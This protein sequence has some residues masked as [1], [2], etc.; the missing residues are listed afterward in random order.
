MRHHHHQHTFTGGARKALALWLALLAPLFAHA[1]D[2][3]YTVADEAGKLSASSSAVSAT[4]VEASTTTV[5]WGSANTDTYYYVP[6]SVTMSKRVTV[7][8]HV[9]LILGD[10]ATLTCSAGITVQGTNS[11]TI[12]TGGPDA[13]FE[14]TGALSATGTQYQAGIGGNSGYAAG[15]ITINAGTVTAVGYASGQSYAAGIGGGRSG[16][17]GTVIINGGTV[18]AYGSQAKTSH[19][20]GIGAGGGSSSYAVGAGGTVIINGGTVSAYS[21]KSG[22]GYGAGIGGSS[23]GSGG[24]KNGST[25]GIITIKGGTV[26]AYSS[27][28]GSAFGAGIGGGAG[29]SA[30]YPGGSAGEIT[31]DGGTVNA[32]ASYSHIGNGAGIGTGNFGVG[33]NVTINGGTIKAY[34]ST[35][36]TGSINVFG[37]GIGA[38]YKGSGVAVVINDGDIEAYCTAATTGSAY[39]HGAGIGAGKLSAGA[40]VT[41]NGGTVKAACTSAH[42]GYG[43][44]IGSGYTSTKGC[45]I[46]ITGGTVEAYCCAFSG[47]NSSYCGYGAGIGSGYQSSAGT[48][49]ISGGTVTAVCTMNKYNQ[50]AYGAGIGCGASSSAT[51]YNGGTVEISGGTVTAYCG[52]GTTV[53]GTGIGGGRYSNGADV[54]ISGGTVTVSNG[55]G[56]GTNR[57]TA[58]SGKTLKVTGDE[59]VVEINGGLKYLETATAA[60]TNT[61]GN[62]V[63]CATYGTSSSSTTTKSGETLNLLSAPDISGQKYAKVWFTNDVY[64][65]TLENNGGSGATSTKT[66]KGDAFTKPDT[67]QREGYVFAGWYSDEA[68][69]TKY[70]FSTI[71]DGDIT[72]YA[73]W[74]VKPTMYYLDE[75]GEMLSTDDYTMIT[76]EDASTH[77]AWTSGIYAIIDTTTVSSRVTVTGEVTLI[78]GD[79]CQLNCTKGIT[80]EDGN[81]FV[82]TAGNTKEG[83]SESGVLT[84]TSYTGTSWSGGMYTLGSANAAIGGIATSN[85]DYTAT[86]GTIKIYGGKV[87]AYCT[88]NYSSA[89]GAGIGGCY[90]GKSGDITI[91]GGTISAAVYRGG[92]SYNN[93]GAIGS[94]SQAAAA[95]TLTIKGD[96]AKIMLRGTSTGYALKMAT[97]TVAATGDDY[98]ACVRYGNT[99]T[100]TT[101]CAKEYN[102]LEYPNLTSFQI[103]QVWFSNDISTVTYYN[104]GEVYAT[105]TVPTGYTIEKPAVPAEQDGKTFLGWYGSDDEKFDFSEEV[106]GSTDLYA[107]W[108]DNSSIGTVYYWD[109]EGTAQTVE[110]FS[111]LTGEMERD[112]LKSGFYVVYLD[113]TQYSTTRPQVVGDVTLVLMDDK[114]FECRPGIGVSTGNSLTIT[115]GHTSSDI[116]GTGELT[117]YTL[118]YSERNFPI[119]YKNVAIGGT[120]A[121]VY[122]ET[123]DVWTSLYGCGT[124]TINGG[125]VNAYAGYNEDTYNYGMAYGAGIGTAGVENTGDDSSL[126]GGDITIRRGTVTAYSFCG[127]GQGLGAGIGEG[128]INKVVETAESQVAPSDVKLNAEEGEDEGDGDG[129]DDGDEATTTVV[130]RKMNINILGGTVNAYSY[131]SGGVSESEYYYYF[132][133]GAGIGYGAYYESSDGGGGSVA[134]NRAGV[135]MLQSA[136][137]NEEVTGS[138]DATTS[139]EAAMTINIS[140]GTVKAYSADRGYSYG[141]GI[142][143][144]SSYFTNYYKNTTKSNVAP[145]DFTA[146]LAARAPR[147]AMTSTRV[148]GITTQAEEGD[149]EGTDDTETV[150]YDYTPTLSINISG[151]N[152]E[153]YSEHDYMG[154]GGGA[155]IG[156]A[157]VNVEKLYA[158]GSGTIVISDSAVVKAYS[159]TKYEW[160]SDYYGSVVYGVSAGIGIGDIYLSTSDSPAGSLTVKGNKA[161]VEAYGRESVN[162]TTSTA[163]AYDTDSLKYS[164]FIDYGTD[165]DNNERYHSKPVAEKENSTE[166]LLAFDT[167]NE[168]KSMASYTY[169]K[170]FF[171]P[172]IDHNIGSTGY[173]TMY[174]SKYNLIVPET[175]WGAMTYSIEN[176]MA[177]D[178]TADTLAASRIYHAGD[179]IPMGL[180]VVLRRASASS[181]TDH[182]FYVSDKCSE[183]ADTIANNLY[184]FDEAGNQTTGPNGETE[185]YVFY[186]LGVKNNNVGFYYGDTNGAPFMMKR[187]HTAYLAITKAAAANIACFLLGGEDEMDDVVTGISNAEADGKA[188]DHDVIYTLGGVRVKDTQNLPKGIYIK[189]GKK[190]LVQ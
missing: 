50:R 43:A 69:S 186:K 172:Y 56:A 85:S 100:D 59:A 107:H 7:A 190:I 65:A 92:F 3:Y 36:P 140:G 39:A 1:T 187:G 47:S 13:S 161:V 109:A 171:A 156:G 72:L 125:V 123:A 96:R 108:L 153:A 35:V 6:S 41:I 124:I 110:Q 42:T 94:G 40:T 58:G 176:T 10:G 120:A 24:N 143:Y 48:V 179:T 81:T 183:K 76:A 5:T 151:G 63:A 99:A 165:A 55:I 80:V 57:T 180:A 168:E 150:T 45:D 188:A 106:T 25:G 19:A 112:T 64:V 17:G 132:G 12:T 51:A 2:V 173:A 148:A 37:V 118:P 135:N 117:A 27:Y 154:Y 113:D 70:D 68:L 26:N 127:S 177:Y 152:V 53:Y 79:G 147:S 75:N 33:G 146:A 97:A 116:E 18:E 121:Y 141:A 157:C 34:C 149:E 91:T 54:T 145:G 4:D 22:A 105:R 122:D 32:Q 126:A 15:T 134:A 170:V 166:N 73:S 46:T 61:A 138:N 114:K 144:G 88:T 102:L 78:L 162:A 181:D 95:G 14:S 8:G 30:T 29:T 104:D 77:T 9:T 130:Y 60:A 83:I 131:G 93:A 119:E 139:T 164:V 182:F 133:Y 136:S 175:V 115:A 23:A 98:M 49:K 174:Y 11:F 67:P 89:N 84:A 66:L 86:A 137:A 128:Y 185:G 111:V 129:D 184:G 159:S 31:I 160:E 167:D 163:M 28:S 90:K 62:Y 20:A 189:N 169:G 87:N 74:M 71:A 21:S 158:L 178:T 82:I 103:A 142:G 52:P 101:I 16:D 44:G 155:G 38:G